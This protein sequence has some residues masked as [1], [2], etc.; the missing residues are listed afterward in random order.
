M[1]RSW[2]FYR[3]ERVVG[4][5][6]S[7]R[8][9]ASVVGGHITPEW[10]LHSNRRLLCGNHHGIKQLKGKLSK[11]KVFTGQ[12]TVYNFTVAKDHDYF[13]GETGFLV[14]NAPPCGCGPGNPPS[15]ITPG[16]LPPDEENLLLD[17]L[18][19]LD[20]GTVPTGPTGV[21]WGSPFNNWGTPPN[22]PGG[23][24]GVSPYQEYRVGSG[25]LGA[26]T[27]RVVHNPATGEAYYTWT[28]YGQAGCPPF[29]R[30]R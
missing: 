17:T 5:D 30:I 6:R 4:S 3:D 12:E 15:W 1:A 8:C 16:S 22:L 2:Q 20:N 9:F 27:R 21:K 13:V 26:G 19:N 25:G 14:H 11:N 24:G 28:H 10:M 29:V 7:P 18:S 23:Q